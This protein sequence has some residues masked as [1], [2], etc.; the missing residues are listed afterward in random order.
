MNLKLGGLYQCTFDRELF[1]PRKRHRTVWLRVGMMKAYTPF[2]LLE[3]IENKKLKNKHISAKRGNYLDLK[4]LSPNG[5][6]CFIFCFS[7]IIIEA[8]EIK[9]I[10]VS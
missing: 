1:A 2:V 3:I 7:D 10:N 6:I 4:I 8:N 5:E 9:K